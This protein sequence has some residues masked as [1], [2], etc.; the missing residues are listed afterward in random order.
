MSILVYLVIAVVI[1]GGA[2]VAAENSLPGDFLYGVK[3]GVNE[4]VMAAF[5]ANAE[6]KAN[7]EAS[8]AERRV[9][10]ME[11]LAV[12]GTIEADVS[13]RLQEN[14]QAHADNAE[15]R[16]AELDSSAA[17]EASSNFE[18][19]LRAHSE[20]LAKIRARE[21]DDA[22]FLSALSAKLNSETNDVFR[23]K[24]AAEGRVSAD[25]GANA[26]ASAE[27]KMRTA[28]AKI[29]EARSFIEAKKASISADAATN[30][31]AKLRT[32]ISVLAQGKARFEAKAYGDAYVLFQ[33]SYQEA[34]EAKLL[35]DLNI[36]T[37]LNIQLNSDTST[38]TNGG[39]DA[40]ADG[41][42]DVRIGL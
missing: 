18:S 13:A 22:M 21:A 34:Q 31:E 35:I 37:N 8:M 19:S 20:I 15:A 39:I 36:D 2:S 9:E 29:A 1:G 38:E 17:L 6:A 10:E 26:E 14:F 7:F 12:K 5:S 28:E 25:L 24:A 3:T 33:Q 42:I 16:I 4:R 41:E 23:L 30:A 32:A 27:A 40:N 11:R